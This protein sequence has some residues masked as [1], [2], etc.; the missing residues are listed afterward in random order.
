MSSPFPGMNPFLEQHDAWRDFHMS[1]VAALREAL[2][3]QVSPNYIVKIEETVMPS[4]FPGMNPFLEQEDAWQDFH[5][6][7]IPALGDAISPQ[8]SPDYIVKIEEHIYIHEPPAEQRF[9]IG[10]GD[11][12]ISKSPAF[13]DHG[14]GVSTM[15]PAA[16][17][18]LLPS[19]EFEAQPYLEIR[20]RV[21]R[22]LI[23]VIELL[24]PTNKRPGPDREQYV[25][26]RANILRSPAHFVE[27]DLLRGGPRMP[28][29][30]PPVCDYCVMVSRANERPEANFWSLSLRDPLPR[31]PIPLRPTSTDV[32]LP[33]QEILHLVYDRAYYKDYIYQGAPSPPLSEGD[34]GWAAEFVK[35]HTE[36]R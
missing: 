11:V 30:K 6:R 20:D 22:E 13:E 1:F 5:D 33:L 14:A 26:K 23:T 15:S 27:I 12:S 17:R 4:P 19:V 18:I 36:P 7:L 16:S 25:A 29:A 21:G 9:R 2:S 8:V 32:W 24:S 31:L 35:S 28:F 10:H 34:A 3:R